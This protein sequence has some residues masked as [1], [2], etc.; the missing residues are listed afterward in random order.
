MEFFKWSGRSWSLIFGRFSGSERLLEGK[1]SLFFE[2]LSE[3]IEL[4]VLSSVQNRYNSEKVE[5]LVKEFEFFESRIELKFEDLKI[6]S[7]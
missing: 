7:C 1:L 6:V 3:E 2:L 4:E 5:F